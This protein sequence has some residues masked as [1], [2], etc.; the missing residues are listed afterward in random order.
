MC[1]RFL[2]DLPG[3]KA[4]DQLLRLNIHQFYLIRIVK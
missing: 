1:L 3:M 2:I 4:V